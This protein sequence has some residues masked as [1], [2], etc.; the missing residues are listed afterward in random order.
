LLRVLGQRFEELGVGYA[1]TGLSAAWLLEPFAMFRLVTLYLRQW[2]TSGLLEQVGFRE[3]PRGANVWLI[4]PRDEGVFYGE[5]VREG[6]QHV[7][8]VQTYLDLK[9]QPE[10]ADEAAEELRRKRLSWSEND[11]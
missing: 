4:L 6:I 8:A 3:E 2:P 7:S 1:A 5:D 11:G 10:R 9:A